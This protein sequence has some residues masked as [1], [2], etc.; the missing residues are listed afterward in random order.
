MTP[1]N[2][3]LIAVVE[4]GR[5]RIR[6]KEIRQFAAVKEMHLAL[7]FQCVEYSSYELESLGL[8]EGGHD[9]R[10]DLLRWHFYY[11]DFRGGIDGKKIYSRLV[12]KRLIEPLPKEKSGFWGF[13]EK[14]PKRYGEFIIGVDKEGS[15]IVHTSDPSCLADNFGA[16]TGEPHYLTPVQFR[17]A[18]LDKYNQKPAKYSVEDGILRCGYLWSMTMDNHHDD[19]VV[20]WLGDLGRYLPDEEQLHCPLKRH[21]SFASLWRF[22]F[23]S[24]H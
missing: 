18:V 5:I 21:Y 12:G 19:R 10:I 1:G 8:K 6:L 17:K 2:E 7:Y 24:P 13:A 23:R 22:R 3:E 4:P 9:R 16:N 14:K 15:E 11:G 20:A